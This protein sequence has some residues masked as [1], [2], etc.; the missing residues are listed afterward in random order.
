[1]TRALF[2][3]ALLSGTVL[4]SAGS[5]WAGQAPAGA[6]A[7]EIPISHRDR[8]YTSDQFSNTVSVTDAA[9]PECGHAGDAPGTLSRL[10]TERIQG[11]CAAL[12]KITQEIPVSLQA[13][14]GGQR[15]KP[16]RGGPGILLRL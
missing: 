7:P 5:A 12:L 6:S 4:A 15:G 2:A 9:R 10:G 8:F 1:M 11:Q 13:C 16:G 14:H 3:A